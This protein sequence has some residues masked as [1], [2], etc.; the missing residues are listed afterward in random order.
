M[1]KGKINGLFAKLPFKA[2]ADKIPSDVR[3][4][5]P[6]LDKAIPFANQIVCGLVAVIAVVIIACSGGGGSSSSGGSGGR[7][8]PASDFSYELVKDTPEN[9]GDYVRITEYTGNGGKVV[10]PEKIEDYPVGEIGNR[11]FMGFD[12]NGEG[13]QGDNITEVVIPYNVFMI[14]SGAFAHCKQL[15]SVTIQRPYVG[16]GMLAFRDCENLTTLNIPDKNE[17][18]EVGTNVLVPEWSDSMKLSMGDDAFLNCK[19]LPLKMRARLK[20]MGFLE[21]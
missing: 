20:E 4:K 21:P 16:I 6:L 9:G 10:I 15:T 2:L 19:K 12:N 1:D 13:G 7:A 5:F 8:S 18:P 3:V 17:N 14:G 11:A